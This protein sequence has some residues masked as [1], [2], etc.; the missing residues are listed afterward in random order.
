MPIPSS[1]LFDLPASGLAWHW[2]EG[3]AIQDL[4]LSDAPLP[5][6]Q[7]GVVLIRNA[8]I[9]LNPVDWKV[10]GDPG[11]GWQSGKVPGVDGAG[12]VVALGAGVAEGWLGQ[13]VAYHQ[14][15]RQPGS[16]AEFTPV[17]AQVLLRLPPAMD[18]VT[19]ASFPCP[20]LTAWLAMDKLPSRPGARLL[21][22]G[23]G[24]AVGLYLVQLALER[25]FHVSA[26]CHSRHWERL[27]ALGVQACFEGPLGET[28]VW[29]QHGAEAFFGIVDCIGSAHAARLTPA[30]QANGHIVCIQGRLAGW[31]WEPFGRTL[32][33]HEV[34]LGATHRYGDQA[35]WSRLT[36]AGERMLGDIVAGQMLSEPSFTADFTELAASLEGVKH[37]QF[38]GKSILTFA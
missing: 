11:M 27:R 36:Q 18:F 21:I 23:A 8:A 19:A 4:H 13:R 28:A 33:V 17:K 30:L 31:S 37:R 34:A 32:S 38:S 5:D 12:T 25:G 16:F 2:R 9:G 3:P 1:V 15:L 35:A 22:S 7:E 6:L 20:A 24:G 29:P 26:M 14:D 10:L